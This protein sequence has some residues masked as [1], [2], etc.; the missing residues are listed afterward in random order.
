MSPDGSTLQMTVNGNGPS[1]VAVRSASSGSTIK[2]VPI[3]PAYSLQGIAYAP[4]GSATYS[5]EI[6]QVGTDSVA[7]VDPYNYITSVSLDNIGPGVGTSID[8]TCLA[9]GVPLAPAPVTPA[10][11]APTIT[12]PTTT[13]PTTTSP[14]TTSPTTTAPT[15]T[16]PTTTSP[17]TTSPTTTLPVTTTIV[18]TS[19]SQPSSSPTTVAAQPSSTTQ[20]S[21]IVPAVHTGKPWSSNLW[22]LLVAT[23]GLAGLVLL[24]SGSNRQLGDT[25]QS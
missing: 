3:T 15:T 23:V 12:S 20:S 4:D 14:T 19:V 11:V 8:P 10:T 16:A 24:R 21:V 17:T 5:A 22:W 7:D 1:Y 25:E 18:P 13:A 6:Q 2:D 9:V